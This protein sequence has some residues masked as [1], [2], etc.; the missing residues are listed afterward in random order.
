METNICVQILNMQSYVYY[1]DTVES[2]IKT[3]A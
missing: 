3:Q 2:K 1:S